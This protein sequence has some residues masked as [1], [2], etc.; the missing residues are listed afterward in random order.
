MLP[1]A[2][3]IGVGIATIIRMDIGEKRARRA[4]EK[5]R[6]DYLTCLRYLEQDPNNPDLRKKTLE[7]G[8]AYSDLMRDSQGHTTFDEVALMNDINAACAGATV[9]RKDVGGGLKSR[10]RWL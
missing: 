3:L 5:A 1:L 8:W 7:L 10:I 4:K 6:R 9:G 2:V